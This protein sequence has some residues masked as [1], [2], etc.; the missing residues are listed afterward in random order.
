MSLSFS[1]LQVNLAGGYNPKVLNAPA[2]KQTWMSRFQSLHT[3]I[4]L[5]AKPVAFSSAIGVP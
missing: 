2:Q 1:T 3:T 5:L 4:L